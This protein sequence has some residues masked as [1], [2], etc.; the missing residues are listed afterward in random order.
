[1]FGVVLSPSLDR[2]FWCFWG[3]EGIGDVLDELE[4]MMYLVNPGL[5]NSMNNIEKSNITYIVK[6]VWVQVRANCRLSV[7]GRKRLV[8][9]K[10]GI[11]TA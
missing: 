8:E 7:V 6:K 2:P 10:Q 11:P 9:V 4:A 1:L 5:S 3:P